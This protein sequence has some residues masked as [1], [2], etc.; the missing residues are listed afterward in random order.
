MTTQTIAVTWPE[1][2]RSDLALITLNEVSRAMNNTLPLLLLKHP[3]QAL[4]L[5]KAIE[6]VDRLKTQVEMTRRSKI[7]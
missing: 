3:K 5:I 1:V 7:L 6:S 2:M 4:D